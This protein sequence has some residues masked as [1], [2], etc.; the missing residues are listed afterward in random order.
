MEQQLAYSPEK[1]DDVRVAQSVAFLVADRFQEL[2]DPDGGVDGE[3]LFVEGGELDRARAGGENSPKT[4]NAHDWSALNRE[5]RARAGARAREGKGCGLVVRSLKANGQEVDLLVRCVDGGKEVK[6][7][8]SRV[9][10]V[11]GPPEVLRQPLGLEVVICSWQLQR[12]AMF[13]S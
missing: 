9:Y 12:S 7:V 1:A 4:L 13:E 3:A 2:V 10:E 6:K 5:G 8:L 11:S